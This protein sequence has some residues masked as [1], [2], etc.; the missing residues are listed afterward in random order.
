M[1]ATS[2][3]LQTHMRRW[4]V[5]IVLVLAAA[6]G[7]RAAQK[8]D[9]Q[10]GGQAADAVRTYAHYS[11]FDDI[12][13]SVMDG[14]VT[15]NGRVTSPQKRN[16]IGARVAKIDGIRSV[17]NDIGVLPD[18]P[19]DASIRTRIA[20]AIYNHP[21]FWRYASMANPPIHIIVEHACAYRQAPSARRSIAASPTR[22]RWWTARSALP[23]N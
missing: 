13:I 10:L 21:S 4:L 19:L 16:D 12:T 9:R 11:I 15:L 5:L 3:R 18:S 14:T 7:L 1:L 20:S 6:P 22:W 17:V 8:D 2:Q 23:T